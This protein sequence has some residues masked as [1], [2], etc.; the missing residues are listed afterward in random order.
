MSQIII[1]DAVKKYGNTTVI[2]GLNLNIRN[3]ELFTLLGPSGC[4]TAEAL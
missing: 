3:G 4:A 2:S 1:K